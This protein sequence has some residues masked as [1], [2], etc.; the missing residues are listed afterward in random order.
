MMNYSQGGGYPAGLGV[1]ADEHA[2]AE[3]T[4]HGWRGCEA[5]LQF[6]NGYAAS[7][8]RLGIQYGELD[9]YKWDF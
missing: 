3:E 5:A 8:Q 7:P 1:A 9:Q 4:L 6:C 2:H